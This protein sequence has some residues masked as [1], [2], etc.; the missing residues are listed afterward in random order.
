VSDDYERRKSA[1]E[2]V[3][4]RIVEGSGGKVSSEKAHQEAAKVARETDSKQNKQPKKDR[5]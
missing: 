2:W 1:V 5:R 3:A 4:R